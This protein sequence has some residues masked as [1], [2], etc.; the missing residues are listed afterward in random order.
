V[1][2]AATPD[3]T[4]RIQEDKRKLSPRLQRVRGKGD[5]S[6]WVQSKREDW[7]RGLGQKPPSSN[8]S[9]EKRERE[10]AHTIIGISK[11]KT[12]SIDYNRPGVRVNWLVRRES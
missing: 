11:V 1:D 5:R 9:T 7:G 10:R 8:P 12:R 2:V 6:A 3:F 4:F